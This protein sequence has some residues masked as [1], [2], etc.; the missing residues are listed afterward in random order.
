MI[1]FA[2][3]AAG[4]YVLFVLAL[5]LLQRSMLY[6]P[7]RTVPRL[8][9][10]GVPEMSAVKLETA[11]GLSL[12]SWYAPAREGQPTLVYF[13]GNAGHIGHRGSKARPY[14]DAG[15]GVL[16]VEYRGYGGNPGSPAEKG[17]YADGRAALDFL[18][19]QGVGRGRTVLYG[20]SLGTGVAVHLAREAGEADPVAGVV[21]E[22]PFSSLA[23]VAAH[24]YW[25][26]PARWLIK[27]RYDSTA[28]IAAVKAPVFIFQGTAD[29]I[30]PNRF[31]RTLF[32]AAVQPKN[33]LWIPGAGH[34]DL[35][36]FR[37][38]RAVME[39]LN[40]YFP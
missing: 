26:T 29:N 38:A 1:Q 35:Y 7:D 39:F 30:I 12:L 15:F 33:S 32:E 18:T 34:N 8:A 37:A 17:L 11:D 19:V 36:D 4:L 6:F 31:G 20:E 16:L 13:H 9:D 22:A 24:H 28:K 40:D 27:D 21:L 5:Y 3:S 10:A 2:A 25:Y 14:L 23:D